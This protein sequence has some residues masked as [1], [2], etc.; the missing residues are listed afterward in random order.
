[1]GYHFISFFFG[2]D[3]SEPTVTHS[4]LLYRIVAK[5]LC[6]LFYVVDGLRMTEFKSFEVTIEHLPPAEGT[7][8]K[9]VASWV[10]GR[11]RKDSVSRIAVVIH[12]ASLIALVLKF[13]PEGDVH[14]GRM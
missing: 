3:S 6:A 9:L 12:L 2:H 10:I 5:D 11:P 13:E 8:R 4:I 1:M 7:F 14:G